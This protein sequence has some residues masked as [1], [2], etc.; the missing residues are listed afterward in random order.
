MKKFLSILF[1]LSLFGQ[2]SFAQ[3][4][5]GYEYNRIPY[6][7]ATQSVNLGANSFSVGGSSNFNGIVST[8]TNLTVSDGTLV[9]TKIACDGTVTTR[10]YIELTRSAGLNTVPAPSV[11]G[12]RLAGGTSSQLMWSTKS[13]G[14]TRRFTGPISTH[15]DYTLPDS[16]GRICVTQH[17]TPYA[18]TSTIAENYVPYT[19]AIQSVD[20]D[21]YNLSSTNVFFK[22]KNTTASASTTSLTVSS[23][24]IQQ[25]IGATTHTFN[26]PDCTT[27]R[28]GATY[29]F[30]NNSSGNLTINDFTGS[31]QKTVL[32]GGY[33]R[34]TCSS[35]SSAA[36]QWDF[37]FLMPANAQYGT[38]AL[39]VTGSI[40]AT[41]GASI[42]GQT[43]LSTL[44]VSST[45]TLTGNTQQT[46]SLTVGGAVT[47]SSLANFYVSKGTS[48]I[49]MGSSNTGSIASIWMNQSIPS[50]T[51][52]IL[53]SD[54]T[55]NYIN[56]T[57]NTNFSYQASDRVYIRNA[58]N[59][60]LKPIRVGALTSPS[61]TLDVTGTM[62]VS[63]TSTLTGAAKQTNTLNYEGNTTWNTNQT[64]TLTTGNTGTVA[65]LS[66][67]VFTTKHLGSSYNPADATTYYIG[68]VSYPISTNR[69][70]GIYIPYNAT[71]VG[72]TSTHINGVTGSSETFTL[73]CWQNNTTATNLSTALTSSATVNTF[74]NSASISVSAG[75][76]IETRIIT[77]TWVTN[78][79]G[80]YFEVTLFYVR[81][82]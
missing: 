82:Q 79:T 49:S 17:L 57:N 50:T 67:A 80:Q 60:F 81:R 12:I 34:A 32:T 71:I 46:G 78:P 58:D 10:G 25:L 38:N 13:D 24:R 11:N 74:S 64:N 19:G 3:S 16:A 54:G 45:S 73:Q 59:Q 51:N 53:N 66:D 44:T 52:Y 6:T 2:T 47:Q 29:E 69:T 42:S 20:L 70:G 72:F 61:A 14:F 1:V 40:V 8:A 75:D 55:N 23:E 28:E 31:A 4:I 65:V 22:Q 35:T 62:S 5:Q 26:L 21:G 43:S 30:N 41:N 48:T 63:G 36:G 68:T 27:L 18:K 33:V 9:A 7:G 56:S 37:H 15:R 77:P 76:Y 39:T